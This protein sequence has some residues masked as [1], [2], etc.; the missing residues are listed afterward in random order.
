M[1]Q[2]WLVVRKIHLFRAHGREF[3]I[4]T[5]TRALI[6]THCNVF[7]R[8]YD[9]QTMT[10]QQI[11]VDKTRKPSASSVALAPDHPLS[12]PLQIQPFVTFRKQQVVTPRL[13][14]FDV[15]PPRDDITIMNSA[16]PIGWYGCLKGR[17][18]EICN[19]DESLHEHSHAL[20]FSCLN[21][22]VCEHKALRC[23]VCACFLCPAC[24][25]DGRGDAHHVLCRDCNQGA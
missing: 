8:T 7:D 19:S 23:T 10:V 14:A 2:A 24:A 13:P 3:F 25:L 18:M 11:V 22:F 16:A 21:R 4:P 5:C 9:K 1:C 20:C 6:F 15:A 17:P 12:I